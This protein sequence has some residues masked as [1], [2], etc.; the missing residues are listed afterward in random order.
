[1]Q[2]TV[3]SFKGSM[4]KNQSRGHQHK[5]QGP[6]PR[7]TEAGVEDVVTPGQQQGKQFVPK[8][9]KIEKMAQA[10]QQGTHLLLAEKLV[11]AVE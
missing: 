4:P 5:Q 10:G 8:E 9:K 2:S 6:H 3:W 7:L 1:M 11:E